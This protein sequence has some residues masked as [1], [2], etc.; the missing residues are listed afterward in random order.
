MVIVGTESGIDE[1]KASAVVLHRLLGV[2]PF[3]RSFEIK[4]AC[5][6]A[7][8]GI[9]FAKTHIQAN[10]ESKVL[11]IA[12]DIA[13]YGLRSGGEPTQGAGAVAMLL[14]ANPRILT[15]E[16]DNLM[17]TQDIYDFWRPLGHAYP[18][19]DGHLSNQVYID[20]FKKCGKLIVN[21]IKPASAIML[22]SASIFLIQKWGKKHC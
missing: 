9:Q 5:Y 10:P 3:A 8:A 1:S 16:N 21:A 11:V 19:V 2:Q 17:L 6:G 4:E 14:T 22:Q 18:M 12:S 15:F 7:T 13:R 20:S